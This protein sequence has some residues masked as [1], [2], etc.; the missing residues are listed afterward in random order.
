ML[1]RTWRRWQTKATARQPMEGPWPRPASRQR[2]GTQ[3]R[4][5]ASGG[6]PSQDLGDVRHDGHV[7]SEAPIL[8][9][10]RDEGLILPAAYQRES[11]KLAERRRTAMFANLPKGGCCRYDVCTWL[12]RASK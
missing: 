11:R 8:R 2:A 6:G 12:L 10:R 4:V 3:A 1:E 9:L 5:D 7:V